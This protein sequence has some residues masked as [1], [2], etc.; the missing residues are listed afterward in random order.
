MNRNLWQQLYF[1]H[2]T[3]TFIVIT[4]LLLGSA[5]YS[6]WRLTEYSTQQSVLETTAA[7]NLAITQL[8]ATEVWPN[9]APLLPTAEV[10]AEGARSNPNLPAIDAIVRR[11]SPNT[12]IVKLKIFDLKGLTL[13]SS[14]AHQIGDDKSMTNGFR[15]AREGKPISELSFRESFMSFDGALQ[16]RNL[17]SSY[18]PVVHNG[19]LR[20]VVE[21]YTDRTREIEMTDLQLTGLLHKLVVVFFLLFLILLAIFRQTERARRDHDQSLIR[22]AEE[23]RLAREAAVQANLTKSQFLATMSHEIRTPMNGVIGMANL[24]L[25]TDLHAEQREFA[26]SIAVSGESLLAI[27]NDILDL[28]K[29]EAGRMEFETYPFS[30]RD[31]LDAIDSLLKVRVQEKGIRLVLDIAPAAEGLFLGDGTRVRQIL[32]NLAGNAVKFT[33]KGEVRITV[34][35][36]PR[37]LLFEVSDTGIGIPPDAVQRLFASFSQVDASTT[38]RFGGTGLGLAISKKLAEGM[39]GSIGIES[40]LGEGSRFWVELPLSVSAATEKDEPL[41]TDSTAPQQRSAHVLLV[42]D[43]RINQ[44]VA[45]AL[46]GRLGHTFD[47]AEN[48][49][50][51]AEAAEAKAYALILM[52]MQMPEMDGLE[53]TR[54]IRAGEGPNANT[55]II[56]LTANAMQ[57][58]QDA[59]R[60]AGM[61]DFLSKP[62][63]REDLAA[64]LNRGLECSKAAIGEITQ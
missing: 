39:G 37:G 6:I 9:L 16:R 58:D 26:R 38:R 40:V 31:M 22:L 44:K 12:D 13:Y 32:L 50:Q 14:E 3:L 24:L 54:R 55:W 63:N 51:G 20:S 8:I 49:R 30:V 34:T 59:C 41:V 4:L 57:S 17:V 7:S 1:R 46:L 33:E 5:L 15:S 48:G 10:N 11:F 60:E 18:V 62:F 53:A 23:S 25:D 45:G 35:P 42:E 19:E 29:I 36:T 47:L 64:A 43:N 21:I 28:S 61:N 52:D 56:A 2:A 27:I